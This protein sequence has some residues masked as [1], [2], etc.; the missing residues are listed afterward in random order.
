MSTSYE[1]RLG[2]RIGWTAGGHLLPTDSTGGAWNADLS[3]EL[4]H[5]G[6]RV[7]NDL[8]IHSPHSA[9]CYR[10]RMISVKRNS[11]NGGQLS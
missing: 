9:Y 5:G 6:F 3:P 1:N 10:L 7:V 2:T 8:D 11:F 4:F